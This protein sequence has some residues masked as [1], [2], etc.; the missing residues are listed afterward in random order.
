M[1]KINDENDYLAAIGEG[2]RPDVT[3]PPPPRLPTSPPLAV[4]STMARSD[5]HGDIVTG[6][7]DVVTG[8]GDVVTCIGDVVTGIGDV[9]TGIGVVVTGIGDIVT[10]IRDVVTGIG[11]VVA[12]IGDIVTGIGDSDRHRDVVTGMKT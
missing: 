5:R 9:V 2:G 6:I 4:H 10:G 11:V 12:G 8:I 3:T 1:S 7:G